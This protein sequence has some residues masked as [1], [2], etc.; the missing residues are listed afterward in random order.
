MGELFDETCRKKLIGILTGAGA[1]YLLYRAIRSGL[2]TPQEDDEDLLID[3][4][5]NS[6]LESIGALGDP[7][8]PSN[9][10][11]S[12]SVKMNLQDL[13]TVLTILHESKDPVIR[14]TILTS[15]YRIPGFSTSQELFRSEGGIPI[16]AESLDD[17][18]N[19]IKASAVTVFNFLSNDPVNRDLLVR[20]IPQ[21]LKLTT[22]TFQEFEQLPCLRFLTKM[23]LNHQNH[24]LLKHAIPD[25]FH[26][27]QTGSS[28]IKFQSLQILI[29]F[30]TNMELTLD[31]LNVQV[32]GSF[33][34]LFNYFQR[35]DV[36]NDLL[37]LV[38]NL[39]EIRRSLP[40]RS[41]NHEYLEDSVCVLLFGPD[42]QFSSRLI[43]LMAF[44]DDRIKLQAARIVTNLV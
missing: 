29:N 33:L 31:M 20:Y 43:Y 16:I 4:C 34:F 25:F 2:V 40:Y 17:P 30:S 12:N 15:I 44:P 13:K 26:L 19:Y 42:S 22:L 7:S 11:S 37:L 41:N 8:V 32:R 23:S 9:S 6:T 1:I 35:Q 21:V 5:G 36:L 24:F 10:V 18:L 38:S 3:R 14:G 27:L 28:S 39:N